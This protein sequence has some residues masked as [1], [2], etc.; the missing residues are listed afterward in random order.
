MTKRLI[1]DSELKVLSCST[2]GKTDDVELNSKK[3]G[4]K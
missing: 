2:D 3:V 1:D 4:V